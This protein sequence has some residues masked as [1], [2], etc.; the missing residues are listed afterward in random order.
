MKS[1]PSPALRTLTRRTL[2]SLLS[3]LSEGLEG[4]V[5]VDVGGKSSRY[6]S[7]VGHKEYI[8][9]DVDPDV[10]PTAVGDIHALPLRSDAIDV[11]IA[12]E[13]LEHCHSPEVAVTELHRILKPGGVCVLSTRFIFPVHGDPDDYYRFT[14]S[15]LRFLFRRFRKVE[16]VPHGNLVMAV[17]DLL[18]FRLPHLMAL[19]PLIEKLKWVSST[20]P[21]GFAVRA[22]K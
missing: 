18:S 3:R 14:A 20:A 6:R 15:A 19:N 13:I 21:L 11:V 2:D 7:L 16:I 10:R 9:V 1:R 8:N 5:I 12:T 17:W 4:N 22:E